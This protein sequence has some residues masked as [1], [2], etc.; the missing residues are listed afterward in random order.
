[1]RIARWLILILVALPVFLAV[2]IGG[3]MLAGYEQPPAEWVQLLRLDE[4][5][6]P[7]WNNIT[8]G[9]TTMQDAR[10]LIES[11]FNT[12]ALYRMSTEFFSEGQAQYY[13]RSGS[14]EFTFTVSLFAADEQSPVTLI[15]LQ[16]DHRDATIA[17]L[18]PLLARPVS[19]HVTRAGDDLLRTTV[20]FEDGVALSS[21]HLSCRGLRPER[22]IN[23][24]LL[25]T[26]SEPTI[27]NEAWRGFR[28]RYGAC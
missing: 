21:L 22:R 5:A 26:E 12:P 7:C 19:V 8:P 9:E 18:Y 23:S 6:L 15:F 16:I 24:L 27:I 13:M 3:A 20:Y 1:M 25:T 11:R 10:R 14:G 17:S 4:C 28:Q 2:L